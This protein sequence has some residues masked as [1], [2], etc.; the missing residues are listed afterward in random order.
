LGR[1]QT[2]FDELE[3]QDTDLR[4]GEGRAGYAGRGCLLILKTPA[5]T[6]FA[7]EDISS[8]T[9]TFTVTQ[10]PDFLTEIKRLT[11]DYGNDPPPGSDSYTGLLALFDG[12]ISSDP[13][14]GSGTGE[15]TVDVTELAQAAATAGDTQLFMVAEES[16]FDGTPSQGTISVTGVTYS[17]VTVPDDPAS[18]SE[19]TSILTF[20]D[21]ILEAA[22]E[23]GVAHFGATGTEAAQIPTDAHD[24]AECKRHVN[25]AIR[26]LF[27]HGPPGDWRWRRPTA[28]VVLWPSVTTGSGITV[29]GGSYDSVNDET[30]LTA[31]ADAF[32]LTMEKKSIVIT[33]VGTFTMKRYI[34]D[35]FMAVEGDASS[36]SA[37]TFAVTADG[38]YTLEKAFSGS[39]TGD[40]GYAAETNQ[41]R[42]I[43]W[44]NEGTIRAMRED[45]LETDYPSLAAVRVQSDRRRWELLTYPV[46]SA[47]VTVEFPYHLA[48]NSLTATTDLTPL[49][50][51]F[52]E[53]VRAAVL[54]VVERDVHKQ[55]QGQHQEYYMG[56][57]LPAAHA[58]DQRSAP[59]NLGHFGNP[60][61]AGV[62][63]RNFRNFRS[64]PVVDTDN[65]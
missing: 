10:N 64:R 20:N 34:G 21:L 7:N 11:A 37:A 41:G 2:T 52:D 14:I 15:V 61:R 50:F 19:P 40:I 51:A 65:I 12:T 29:T 44:T 57:A 18:A 25:N 39:Y 1:Y 63:A 17:I 6:G 46:P 47:E 30:I 27:N 43:R 56:V 5:L 22:L 38:N 3:V 54:Y 28:S 48:F 42:E 31:S 49:P 45:S 59:R 33:G 32:Y 60:S 35:T 8:A 4:I 62:N 36:A 23:M 13:D 9:I 16:P 58:L 55:R 53:V 24:L 26:M